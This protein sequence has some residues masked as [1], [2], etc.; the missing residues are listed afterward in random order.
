MSYALD[1]LVSMAEATGLESYILQGLQLVNNMIATAKPSGVLPD[2]RF[3]VEGDSLMGGLEHVAKRTTA[4]S[5]GRSYLLALRRE[6]PQ[7][8]PT[9]TWLVRQSNYPE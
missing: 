6:A 9:D 2:E 3:K 8:H 4:G 1:S 5:A 7:S